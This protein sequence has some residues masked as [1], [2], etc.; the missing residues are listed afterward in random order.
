VEIRL[1]TPSTER[2]FEQWATIMERV[3]GDLYDVDE[4]AHV[5]QDD[6][7]SAWILA[8]RGYEALGCGVGRTSSIAGSL[9]A[10][11]RVLPEHRG[12]GVGTR[13]YEALSEHAA[14]LGLTS[15][16]GRIE[17]GDAA[18]LRFA[19]NRG[20]REVSREYEVVLDVAEA[21]VAADPPAGVELVR[22][23]ERPELVRL[24]YEVDVEV[25][26]DVPSHEEGYEP[27]T[28]ERWHATYLE[29]PGALPAACIV[30][31]VEGE[32]VGY[33]G[34]RRRGSTSPTAEN[35]LTAV[36]RPWRRR[37]IATALKREQIARAREAGIEQ[38]YT[39]N[40]ETNVG[41][42]GVNARL[43]YRPAPTR[44][45]VSGPLAQSMSARR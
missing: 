28:F 4:L 44:I 16:W 14:R 24:V 38:I 36:R 9:Y 7:K 35:L 27:M 37:G 12:Q 31:L 45:L 17:E 25:G 23:A 26:A 8:S 21:D 13:L 10:M 1:E 34:L 19:E 29:G 6:E 22:L 11:A 18:S 20:F 5:I 41:M 39:T 40:D 30:A 15:L 2:H 33:T 42:R 43:G 32:V 3:E